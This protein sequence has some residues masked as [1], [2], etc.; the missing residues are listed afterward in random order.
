MANGFRGTFGI[1]LTMLAGSLPIAALSL[2]G[3]AETSPIQ[4][5]NTSKLHFADAVYMG[6]SVTT[7]SPT[8][9]AEA[10]RVFIQGAT[11]FV[12]IQ[13]VRDDAEQRAKRIL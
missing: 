13:S 9:G 11:G 3:C 12:S 5:A 2:V 7:G 1:S 10:Y 6:E 8:P 4:P